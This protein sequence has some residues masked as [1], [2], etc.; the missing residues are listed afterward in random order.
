MDLLCLWCPR[1]TLP[2]RVPLHLHGFPPADPV[3]LNTVMYVALEAVRVS[4]TRPPS[5]APRVPV[6]V[7][8]CV[9]VC[10][11][12]CVCLPCP[13]AVCL[14]PAIPTSAEKLLGHLGVPLSDASL[15]SVDALGAFARLP[16]ARIGTGTQKLVLFQKMGKK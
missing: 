15:A 1:D 8:A 6:N 16:G 9:C 14:L 7:S 12:V 10:V 2:P 3:R 5:H 11:C 4:G 13:A